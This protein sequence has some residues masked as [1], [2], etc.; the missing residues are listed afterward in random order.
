MRA[1]EVFISHASA[2]REEI[3]APLSKFLE[4]AGVRCW[5][6]PRDIPLGDTYPTA[7][8]KGLKNC[9][10]VLVVV[11][12]NCAASTE[13]PKEVELGSKHGKRMIAL[14]MDGTPLP[15]SLEYALSAVQNTPAQRGRLAECAGDYRPVARATRVQ[16]S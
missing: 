4:D 15:E 14:L 12:A 5:I 1:A 8:V 7:I 13:V 2:D 16:R 10:C 3:A 11:T 9:R 6:A